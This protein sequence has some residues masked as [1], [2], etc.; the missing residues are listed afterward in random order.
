[1]GIVTSPT[2]SL[3]IKVRGATLAERLH[4]AQFAS[5]QDQHRTAVQ[6]SSNRGRRGRKRDFRDAE[7][8][9]KRLRS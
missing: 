6:A 1:V 5:I 8:L 4:D 7:R 9:V 2:Y 3:E